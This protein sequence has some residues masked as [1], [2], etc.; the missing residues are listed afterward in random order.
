[1]IMVVVLAGGDSC[2][3]DGIIGVSSTNGERRFLM[4]DAIDGQV[5]SSSSLSSFVRV[6]R[7]KWR[8]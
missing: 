2:G 6:S 7:V 5:D 1:V 4:G 3:S 8:G